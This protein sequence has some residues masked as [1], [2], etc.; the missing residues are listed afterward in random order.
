MSS[1]VAGGVFDLE[2]GQRFSIQQPPEGAAWQEPG[3]AVVTDDV[4][5]I[6]VYTG[7]SAKNLDGLRVIYDLE[8]ADPKPAGVDWLGPSGRW[9]EDP[10]GTGTSR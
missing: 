2:R 6:F 8:R 4:S 7:S 10:C 3:P 9:L 5:A 1:F